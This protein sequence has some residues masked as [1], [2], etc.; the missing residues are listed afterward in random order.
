MDASSCA[1]CEPAGGIAACVKGFGCRPLERWR[2]RFGGRRPKASKGGNRT[3]MA[4]AQVEWLAFGRKTGSPVLLGIALAMLLATVSFAQDA[5]VSGIPLGPANI[6][7][8]NNTG[9]DPSGIGNASKVAPLPGPS[10]HAV[11]PQAAPPHTPQS[12]EAF[13]LAMLCRPAIRSSQMARKACFPS[14]IE[15]STTRR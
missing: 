7:G 13:L 4:D 6:N 8:L 14:S 2:G 5:G 3:P 15:L 11:T 10:I 1:S 12:A 9:R